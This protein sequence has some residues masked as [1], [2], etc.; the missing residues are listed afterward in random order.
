MNVSDDII[1]AY[2]ENILHIVVWDQIFKAQ[3]ISSMWQNHSYTACITQQMR[4]RDILM[5]IAYAQDIL[6]VYR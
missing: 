1:L 2:T 5:C 4:N 6:T 3:D